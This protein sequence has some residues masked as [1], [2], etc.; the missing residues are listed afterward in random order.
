MFY[1][2]IFGPE[3]GKVIVIVKINAPKLAY[4]QIFAKKTQ[5]KF[6]NSRPK[7]PYLGIFGLEFNKAIVIFEIEV[8]KFV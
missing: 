4:L 2:G 5:Q 8:L 3:F 6:L 7:V 1:L